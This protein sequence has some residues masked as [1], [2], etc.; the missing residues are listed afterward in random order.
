MAARRKGR[1]TTKKGGHKAS[2]EERVRAIGDEILTAFEE[3]T[4]AKALATVFLSNTPDCE[5]PSDKW[6]LM[7]RLVVALAG[8]RM[9]AGF[10]QWKALGR[11][12]QKGEKAV[13]ILRP[14]TATA[15]EDDEARGVEEGDTVVVGYGTVPVF[16]YSQ[17]E[18]EPLPGLEE[19]E[20][21]LDSLPLVEVATAWGLQVGGFNGAEETYL[22]QYRHGVAIELG[23]K[24]LVVWAHELVHAAEDRLGALTK[25]AGQQLDNEVVA[26]LGASILLEALGCE[27]ESDRGMTFR[28]IQAYCKE[29]EESLLKTCGA[30]LDRTCQAVSYILEEANRLEA[31]A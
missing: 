19:Q 26:Q 24:N 22:G 12:V 6:S 28:Y 4:V 2:R 30:L 9:A 5:I 18:G 31:A 10:R 27:D 13:H 25:K 3:G 7:N 11:H 17:T 8:H 23:V 29:H 1:K 16:G 20:R 14:W 21:F 15:A